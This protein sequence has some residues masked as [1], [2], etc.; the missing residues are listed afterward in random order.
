MNDFLARLKIDNYNFFTLRA[1]CQRSQIAK[2][3]RGFSD[4]Q[5]SAAVG[6]GRGGAEGRSGGG[7][8]ATLHGV[9]GLLESLTNLGCDAR[10]LIHLEAA[11]QAGRAR[12]LPF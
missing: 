10:I 2:K 7:A 11:A 4:A 12:E 5:Q 3:L 1:F 8:R 9:V 6:G